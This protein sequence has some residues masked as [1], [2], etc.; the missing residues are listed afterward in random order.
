MD[1]LSSDTILFIPRITITTKGKYAAIE[2]E[3]TPRLVGLLKDPVSEVRLN[4]LKVRTVCP[5]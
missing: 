5:S 4:A 1:F 3:A 2:A